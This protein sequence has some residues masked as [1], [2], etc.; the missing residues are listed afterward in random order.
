MCSKL[1]KPTEADAR[2]LSS[3]FPTSSHP[4]KRTSSVFDPMADC[5]ASA[6]KRK[7]K[8]VRVK[9]RKVT[10]VLVSGN[11]NILPRFGRRKALKREGNIRQ[12]QF[13]RN[14]SPSQV[15][16]AILTG[17]SDKVKKLKLCTCNLIHIP[18]PL[19]S[20]KN[21]ILMVEMSL[22]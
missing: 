20:L 22:I 1:G 3:L 11:T 16:S 17:F 10:V 21:M 12:L 18:T 6:A 13:L 9:P 8:A 2:V 7:K 19:L 5:V 14:M 15:R 4:M